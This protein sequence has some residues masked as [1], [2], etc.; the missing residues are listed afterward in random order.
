NNGLVEKQGK[1]SDIISQYL[2]LDNSVTESYIKLQEKD[3]D[4]YFTS[5]SIHNAENLNS[6][7][8]NND[9][10]IVMLTFTVAKYIESAELSICFRNNNGVNVLFTSISDSSI[11]DSIKLT[12][13]KYQTKTK[14]RKNFLLPGVY[15]IDIYA[16]YRNN[17]NI[18]SYHDV[19]KFKIED[20]DSYMAPYGKAAIDFSCV[21][22][23]CDWNISNS[24]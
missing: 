2:A 10:F 16:H 7:I 21:L 17:K 6:L 5:I 13:G 11:N 18:D 19:L 24:N 12:P 4:I 20:I 15:S 22:E 3:A 23:N 14:I 8:N 1:T 9:D